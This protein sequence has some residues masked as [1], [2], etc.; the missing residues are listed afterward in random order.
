VIGYWKKLSWCG[1]GYLGTNIS[2]TKMYLL[3]VMDAT[4]WV[5]SRHNVGPLAHFSPFKKFWKRKASS[6]VGSSTTGVSGSEEIHL[7]KVKRSGSRVTNS[8]VGV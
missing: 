5:I 8:L 4:E 6:E 2:T 7:N 3:G 1:L